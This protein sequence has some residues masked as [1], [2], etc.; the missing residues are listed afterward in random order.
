MRVKVYV[1]ELTPRAKRGAVLIGAFVILAATAL[2]ADAS[3][4]A[5]FLPGQVLSASAMNQNFSG[6]DS[7]VGALESF[8]STGTK[9]VETR[10]GKKWS[11]GATYCGATGASY[12]GASVG[13]YANAKSLC[14]QVT[15]GCN[16]SASAHM[17]TAEELVRTVEMG[18]PFS[19]TGWYSQGAWSYSPSQPVYVNDCAAWT[20]SSTTTDIGPVWN[21][22]AP[23]PSGD[24]CN[25]SHPVLC[26]D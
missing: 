11:L 17:C 14:E 9:V 24:H 5:T 26:C 25:G 12:T 8:T 7:R 21:N 15:L 6:L 13:G 22:G 16:G 4:P 19:T 1:I 18:Q 23:A 3:P 2:P 10:S 20:S